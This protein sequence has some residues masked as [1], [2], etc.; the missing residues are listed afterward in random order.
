MYVEVVALQR[1]L[2]DEMTFV[3][4]VTI[5]DGTDVVAEESFLKTW[6]LKNTGTSTWKDYTLEYIGDP[7]A[8]D[9][10][11]GAPLAISIPFARPDQT[12][13]VSVSLTAPSSPGTHR[14]T[15]RLRKKDGGLFGQQLFAEIKVSE[16]IKPAGVDGLSYIDDVTIQDNTEL[17]PQ[18][19]IQKIWRIRNSGTTEWG[20]GYTMAH[21]G[22]NRLGAP[23]QLPLPA[24]KPGEI[25]HVVIDMETPIQAGDYS[26]EWMAKDSKGELFGENLTIF[27]KVVDLTGQDNYRFLTDVTIPDNTIMQAGQTLR[28]VWRV[29]NTGLTSWG[30]GYSLRH[31]GNENLA[32]GDSFPL[33]NAQP[34]QTVDL[35]IDITSPTTPGLH[36]TSWRPFNSQNQPF[37][38][39]L[40]AL[41][42]TPAP[43][44]TGRRSEAR[45]KE[46]TTI[47]NGT[48]ITVGE[49]FTKQWTITNTGDS[50]WGAG[51][52][53]A[54]VDGERMDGPE[55]VTLRPTAPGQ[56]VLVGVPLTAPSVPGEYIARWRMRD[57][58]GKLFGSPFQVRSHCRSGRYCRRYASFYEGRRPFVRD[59]AFLPQWARATAGSNP[60]GWQKV[61]P[62]E[63]QRMGRAV[64]R[65]FL[66]ISWNRYIP[67]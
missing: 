17:V 29:R 38:F 45:L 14:S 40:F 10:Q 63:K 50:T 54:F 64:V 36:K 27:I 18:Q 24:A 19:Q 1:T 53:L 44:V 33:P 49:S 26:G 22:G 8:R 23:A 31:V 41:I 52:T 5:P 62:C 32:D 16:K 60:S 21:I 66:Y 56:S 65:R 61:L 15:W 46:H 34:G 25:V 35:E 13:D 58:Q 11:M 51:F 37:G 48:K 57:A 59:E 28:K 2:R 55:S 3:S 30:N 12:I 67:R 42:R 39:E 9:S 47:P 4:D 6:R 7:F 20:Q 43:V